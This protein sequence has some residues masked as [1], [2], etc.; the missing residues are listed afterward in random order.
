MTITQARF[1][2]IN[3]HNS[4]LLLYLTILTAL[5]IFLQIGYLLKFSG[6]YLG[7]IN[8]V[9]S[10]IS[11]PVRVVPPVVLFLV[12]QLLL[13][14]VFVVTLWIAAQ[15]IGNLLHLSWHQIEY[16]GI[17]L[18][19]C[20]LIAIIFANQYYFPN[21]KFSGLSQGLINQTIAGFLML[22]F[23]G[24]SAIAF[25]LALI[26][27]IKNYL[28]LSIVVVCVFSVMYFFNNHTHVKVMDS[29]SETKPNV[30][31]I[32]VDSLRPDFL[33]FFGYSKITPH[34]DDFLNKATVFSESFTPL[35]RTF[36][37]WTSILTGMYPL[38]NGA[39]TNLENPQH[40]DLHATLPRILQQH[41]YQTIFATDETR[42]SNIDQRFGFDRAITPPI[43]F[44]D[45]LIGAMN[46]FP[47]SN[48]LVNTPVGKRLFPY[49]YA[50]RPAMATYDPNSFLDLIKPVLQEP[51]NKPVFLAVHF[52]L[53]HYPYYWGT[54]PLNDK[55]IHNYQA[56]VQR[57]DQQVNDFLVMLDHSQLLTHSIVVLL[58]DHGEAIELHG[59][60]VTDPDLYIAGRS[61]PKHTIPAFYPP[62]L[63]GEQ[64]DASAG[65]G[66]DV[67]GMSQY[68]TVLA[69]RLYGLQKTNTEVIPGIVS[70][71]DI[72]PTVM[73]FLNLD[74]QHETG[75]SLKNLVLGS[76]HKIT[77]RQDLFIESDFSPQAIRTVHP[78]ERDVLFAG[79][80]YFQ[81]DPVT[82]RISV[83][84]SM[85]KMIISS[86]QYADIYGDWV[87]ALYP[88][89][90][91]AMVPILV[92][93]RTGMWTD[94]MQTAFAQHSPVQHMLSALNGFYFSMPTR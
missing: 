35:A 40:L 70:L 23:G 27:V 36:P 26:G 75:K 92:N 88:Q 81:I 83:K 31:L 56:A 57:V 29:A 66:T 4:G 44:N 2:V 78:E 32:G 85:E 49:N 74:V 21:S 46:D 64:V 42:F 11:I 59:D 10:H 80:N 15:C 61:N 38:K 6:F 51:R 89:N 87:L 90:N 22:V 13:H 48:L 3:K 76:Q 14:S 1:R 73:S 58:S 91:H 47:L 43:G 84:S 69:V 39:R 93:L 34:L 28:R 94:D 62:M 55:S 41:G 7:D 45:F 30:I 17:G 50:N 65:H 71:L 52:C 8:L 86:K 25:L 16:T 53:P 72:K 5:F 79:I 33:G 54:Q 60:R 19:I 68:H 20:S 77:D 37:S 67:L 63:E 9:A 24:I 12:I 82:T 18:W